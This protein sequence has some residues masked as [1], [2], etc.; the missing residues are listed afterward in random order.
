MSNKASI[1]S[2]IVEFFQSANLHSAKSVFGIV[3]GVMRARNEEN[4]PLPSLPEKPRRK[5]GPN[6][7]KVASPTTTTPVIDS[8]FKEVDE[9]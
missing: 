1:E 3:K 8:R 6:K 9:K 4:V 2:K 5:R 7:P